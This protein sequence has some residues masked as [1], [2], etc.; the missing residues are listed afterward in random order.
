MRLVDRSESAL[1]DIGD[2]ASSSCCCV[3]DP[4]GPGPPM[5]GSR[6]DC[7][8]SY[9]ETGQAGSRLL[10]AIRALRSSSSC[11]QQGGGQGSGVG[12]QRSGVGS[13]GQ[14][15]EQGGRGGVGV[16]GGKKHQVVP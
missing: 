4:P 1:S 11:R 3:P 15:G 10:A 6:S 12:G 13:R 2:S 9:S 5:G 14:G 16:S 7:L 8:D